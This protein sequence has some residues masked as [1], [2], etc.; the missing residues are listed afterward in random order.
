MN[1][2]DVKSIKLTSGEEIVGVVHDITESVVSVQGP[3][4]VARTMGSSF[5]LVPWMVSTNENEVVD[6]NVLSVIALSP[7]DDQFFNAYVKLINKLDDELDEEE[8]EV[9][10]KR[11]TL[12]DTT[13][14]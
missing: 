5:V 14:H 6:I 9:E 10:D 11:F 4:S 8:E 7:T 1:K 12:P 2:E 13:Y 3:F